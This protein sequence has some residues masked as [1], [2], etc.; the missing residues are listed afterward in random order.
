MAFDGSVREVCGAFPPVPHQA[1]ELERMLPREVS[2]RPLTRWS[3]RGRCAL[4]SV[5]GSV[6]GGVDALLADVETPGTPP[7]D[8]DQIAQA[9][10][11]RTD[12]VA[13]PPYII[14]A[15]ARPLDEDETNLNLLLLLGGAGF[16]DIGMAAFANGLD[17]FDEQEISGK[18]VYVGTVDM[19]DQDDHQRGLPYL[20]ETDDAMFALVTELATW[21][22][23]A[24][25]KL[26]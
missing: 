6:P 25:S 9:I 14:F 19:L 8:V 18:Q 5:A 23:E 4:Q 24:L 16:N 15:A 21:A 10:A 26:P 13:D 7:I 2:G 22:E 12:P 17:G 3:M 11:G 1:L 20:Y